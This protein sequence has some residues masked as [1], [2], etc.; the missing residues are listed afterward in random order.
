MLVRFSH[1]DLNRQIVIIT[2]AMSTLLASKHCSL[3]SKNQKR[4]YSIFK[5]IH[6]TEY[7]TKIY[8]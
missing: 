8:K 7:N 4:T 6:I 1:T 2:V 3:S 5:K